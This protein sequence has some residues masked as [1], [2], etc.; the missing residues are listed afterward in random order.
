[1]S[2]IKTRAEDTEPA[3]NVVRAIPTWGIN[4]TIGAVAAAFVAI[5]NGQ[6]DTNKTLAEVRTRV[7]VMS[8]SNSQRDKDIGQLQ[9]QSRDMSKRLEAMERALNDYTKG[10]GYGKR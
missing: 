8:A 10:N 3:P 4:S 2:A 1:M 5:Y 7:E 6:T 9:D